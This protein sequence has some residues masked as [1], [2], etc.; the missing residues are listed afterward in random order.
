MRGEGGELR[1]LSQWVRLDTG[2]Q[3]NFGDLT[4]YLTYLWTTS[5]S[6]FTNMFLSLDPIWP[7]QRFMLFALKLHSIFQCCESG[8]D[9]IGIILTNP[10]PH[11]IQPNVKPIIIYRH[12]KFLFKIS[13]LSFR[14][15]GKRSRTKSYPIFR[16]CRTCKHCFARNF[17]E[18]GKCLYLD[19]LPPATFLRGTAGVFR[20]GLSFCWN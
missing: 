3:I 17:H 18:R 19:P 2:A 4:P 10:T 5:I 11:P 9:R 13:Y 8:S 15:K 20:S 1:G 7:L 16:E 14:K 6:F 12:S